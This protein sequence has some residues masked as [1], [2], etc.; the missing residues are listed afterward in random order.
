MIPQDVDVL[1]VGA[2]P[3]GSVAAWEAKRV[4]PELDVVLLERDRAVGAPVRCAEG[5]GDVARFEH[6][7]TGGNRVLH[8]DFHLTDSL[9]PLGD[10]VE[11]AVQVKVLERRQ[12]AVDERLMREVAD[13]G[14]GSVD[15]ELALA[16]NSE[17]RAQAEQRGLAGAVRARDDGER[18]A[19]DVEVDAAQDPLVAEALADLPCPDHSG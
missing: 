12:F 8:P 16:R 18:A 9:A 13:G 3:A 10:P 11:P 4:G 19:G 14:T 2:G 7:L 6:Q 5:V 1:V 17:P 15:L